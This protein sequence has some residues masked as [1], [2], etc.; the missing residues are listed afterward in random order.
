MNLNFRPPRVTTIVLFAIILS[1]LSSCAE[2]EAP[3]GGP[4]DKTAPVLLGSVPADGALSVKPGRQ[5]TLYFSE[6]VSRPRDDRAVFISPRP[7]EDPSIK[8]KS[9]RVVITLPDS[10]KTDQTYV[11]SVSTQIKDLRN[12]QLDSAVTIAF[13][14]GTHLD[15]GSVAGRILTGDGQPVAGAMVGLYRIENQ[16][17]SIPYDSIYPLYTTTS[18]SDGSFKFKYLPDMTCRLIAFVDKNHD[19]RFNPLREKFALPDRNIVI[20]GQ[21]PLDRLMAAT[22]EIDTGRTEI[23]SVTYTAASLAKIRFSQAIGLTQLAADPSLISARP[24]DDSLTVYKAQA[25]AESY[26]DSAQTIQVWFDTLPEGLYDLSVDMGDGQE[27]ATYAD[28]RV[29]HQEDKVPPAVTAFLPGDQPQFLQD[30]ELQLVMSEPIDQDLISDQTFMLWT[31]QESQVPVQYVPAGPFDL[32]FEPSALVPGGRYSLKMTEFDIADRSGNLLGDSLADYRFSILDEDSLGSVSGKV[33]IHLI[34]R[35]G[36]PVVLSLRKADNN[37]KFD[38]PCVDGEFH[39]EVP[40]GKY[41]L[42]GFIDVDSSG[43]RDLGAIYPFRNAETLAE[44]PDTISVR[45]RFETADIV[46]EFK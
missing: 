43:T 45:A 36:A 42:S 2:I 13:S 31:D 23:I 12:N 9:D 14:T 30:V 39:R 38:L 20:G 16:R 1:L 25:F 28:F 27:P 35:A 6:N 41:T 18:S 33:L 5:I 44:Y 8:W 22:T 29:T 7:P 3:S 11:V 40:A 19:E 32:K 15:T 46:F 17:D 26:L 37:Q 24:A 21:L 10:F 34:D 4:E